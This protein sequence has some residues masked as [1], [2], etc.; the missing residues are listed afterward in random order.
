MIQEV[1]G[2]DQFRH[3]Q[4]LVLTLYSLAIERHYAS[5]VWKE[6]LD[7]IAKLDREELKHLGGVGAIAFHHALELS[8]NDLIH[9]NEGT[10]DRDIRENIEC[11]K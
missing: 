6:I 7:K 4:G 5:P 2:F 1:N 9:E 8:L 11:A 3:Q 10:D